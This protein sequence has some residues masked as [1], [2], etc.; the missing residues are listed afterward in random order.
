MRGKEVANS[1]RGSS[2]R[3]PAKSDMINPQEHSFT[4]A[5]YPAFGIDGAVTEMRK[6]NSFASCTETLIT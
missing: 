1:S 2:G 5:S 3:E 6:K 4:C